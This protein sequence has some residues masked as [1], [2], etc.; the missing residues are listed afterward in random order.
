MEKNRKTTIMIIATLVISIVGLGIAFAAFSTTLNINGNATVEASAWKVVFEGTTSTTTLAAPITTGTA[1]EVTHPTIK[2]NATEISNYSVSLMTPGDSVTYNFKIHNDGDF[3]ASVSSVTISGV[4]NPSSPISG[5]ALVTDSSIATANA[6]TLAAI[7]YKLYYTDTN[8][9]V[10]QDEA[11]DC[12]EPGEEENVSLRIVFAST[13]ATDTSILPNSNLTLDNLGVSVVYNQSSIGSCAFDPSKGKAETNAP[14][15]NIDGAYYTYEGKSFIGT[16]V[17]NVIISENITSKAVYASATGTDNG[18]DANPRYTF[19]DSPAADAAAA[20]CTGC[21]LMTYAEVGT[22]AGCT[23]SSCKSSK[24]I[25]KYNG[26]ANLWWLADAAT[27]SLAWSV[28]N[29]GNVGYSYVFVTN[30]Y[31]VRPAVDISSSATI[32]GSGTQASPYVI[33]TS[34]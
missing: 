7:E 29:S 28:S 19:A 3:A 4:S 25:A 18:A 14:F 6:N 16:G 10:G 1:T 8:T 17:N 30:S 11:K 32:T 20:Y 5:S 9:L 15:A 31:G 27:R 13:D 12:L 21:R 24:L 33:T 26:S 22:W 23:G 34:N 2:N